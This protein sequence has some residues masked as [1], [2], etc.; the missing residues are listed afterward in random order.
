M[1]KINSQKHR[2]V[3]QSIERQRLQACFDSTSEKLDLQDECCLKD[4]MYTFYAVTQRL[5]FLLTKFQNRAYLFI[6]L[7]TY[8]F[9]L[10]WVSMYF[11][12]N[13]TF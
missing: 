6:Y 4:I 2:D 7:L 1:G 11:H 9:L 3:D 13:S 10:I 8:I 12:I 5:T